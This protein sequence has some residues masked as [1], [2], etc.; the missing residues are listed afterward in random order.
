MIVGAVTVLEICALLALTVGAFTSVVAL[1]VFPII[2]TLCTS[3]DVIVVA[4]KFSVPDGN[5]G[6]SKRANEF[7]P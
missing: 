1:I 2:D 7:C 6:V 5:K 4:F 3:L